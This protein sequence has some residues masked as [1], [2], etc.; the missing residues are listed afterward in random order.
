MLTA[1]A[2]NSKGERAFTGANSMAVPKSM[3]YRRSASRYEGSH[4]KVRQWTETLAGNQPAN[5]FG[6]LLRQHSGAGVVARKGDVDN[7]VEPVP[8]CR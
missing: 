7:L 4:A 1:L 6:V 5:T 3:V 8:R 2:G